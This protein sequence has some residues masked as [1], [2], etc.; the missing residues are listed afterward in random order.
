MSATNH[1][2]LG[3]PGTNDEWDQY[4]RAHR[5][6]QGL[7]QELSEGLAA[8]VVAILVRRDNASAARQLVRRE[9]EDRSAA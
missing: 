7:P 2:L 5:V 8:R 9:T 6:G 4:V 3:V 1:V